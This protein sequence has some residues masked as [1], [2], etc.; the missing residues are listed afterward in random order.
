M[1]VLV[2][3]LSMSGKQE[4]EEDRVVHVDGWKLASDALMVGLASLVNIGYN[5][6]LKNFVAEIE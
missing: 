6:N 4:E 2:M 3:N 1:R 5:W